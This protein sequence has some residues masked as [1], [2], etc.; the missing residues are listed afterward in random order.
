ML[1]SLQ[2]KTVGGN[3]TYDMVLVMG[4]VTL[5]CA[6][7]EMSRADLLVSWVQLRRVNVPPCIK[8]CFKHDIGYRDMFKVG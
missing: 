8:S 5:E 2:E 1:L 3:A 6:G 4:V 7:R